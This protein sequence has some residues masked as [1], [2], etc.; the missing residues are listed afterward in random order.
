MVLELRAHNYRLRVDP[1][2]GASLLSAQ[3]QHPNGEWVSLLVPLNQPE[4]GFKAGCF[5]MAP[6]ANR[7]DGGKFVL[8]DQTV[9]LPINLPDEGMAIHGFS[10][11]LPW[12]VMSLTED[13]VILTQV[14]GGEDHAYIY[15]LEQTIST[16]PEGFHLSL[17]IRNEGVKRLPF[18]FGFHPWFEKTREA[19]LEFSTE[20]APQLDACGLPEGESVPVSGFEPGHPT[21]LSALPLINHC[22]SGWST[23][24]ALIKWPEKQTALILKGEGAIRHLHVFNPQ[25]RAVFC[26]EPVSHFPDAI[27]RAALGNDRAMT[28]LNPG[29]S[30]SGGAVFS[31][32]A[33]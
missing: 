15:H 28:I 27:N 9:Q 26:A 11:N 17:S 29:E 7:I 1:Q 32:F 2:H 5:V 25:D 31:S 30:L 18:G 16:L 33:L 21:P 13:Q 24:E 23:R 20:G 6:F 22:F 3:W 19:T 10:R 12:Q 14:V 4:A 8:D